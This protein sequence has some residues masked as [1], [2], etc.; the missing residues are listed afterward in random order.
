LT[1]GALSLF[2]QAGTVH[3]AADVVGYFTPSSGAGVVPLT[4]ARLLDTRDGT[5]GSIGPVVPEAP[6]ALLV[7][8][9]G[10]VPA[11]ARA[12]FL[13]V[14]VVEPTSPTY[15]TAWPGGIERP[16][17]SSINVVP[18][19]VRANL[20]LA[21]LGADGTVNLF[22]FAGSAHLVVDVLGALVS[23]AG[24]A[25]TPIMPTR[26]L[27]SRD[28]TG[29]VVGPVGQQ[30]SVDVRVAGV[31]GVP[32]DASGVLVNVTAVDATTPTFVTVHPAGEERPLAS[33]LNPPVDAAIPN[34]VLARVGA[35]GTVRLYNNTG[36]VQLVM[37]VLG[38]VR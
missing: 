22:V 37:D 7:G 38:Y 5:G 14:T 29:G 3:L 19:E 35:N 24:G 26:A 28:G 12:A 8:G 34:A 2:N 33:N 23:G 10:G 1:N 16:G 13:N 25:F 6:V 36:A 30:A 32:N 21:P 15:V 27:D 17:T 20:V 31:G 9:R 18:G 4:P 11:G